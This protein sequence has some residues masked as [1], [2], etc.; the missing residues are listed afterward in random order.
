[1]T[2]HILSERVRYEMLFSKI[3]TIDSI[4]VEAPCLLLQLPRRQEIDDLK[5]FGFDVRAFGEGQEE[6]NIRSMS[7]IQIN[8]FPVGGTDEPLLH[9]FKKN[10]KFDEMKKTS[11]ANCPVLAAFAAE[12]V[13]ND[14]DLVRNTCSSVREYLDEFRDGA[15]NPSKSS[16]FSVDFEFKVF[17]TC[18]RW[19]MCD[20][21]ADLDEEVLISKNL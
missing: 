13:A 7:S 4:V 9:G 16:S 20:P 10:P 14:I 1:M 5:A 18:R 2:I 6:E 15:T 17:V 21:P 11:Q 3:F 12:T 19:R 8:L